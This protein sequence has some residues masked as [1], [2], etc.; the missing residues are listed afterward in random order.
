MNPPDTTPTPGVAPP[1]LQLVG[2]TKRYPAVVANSGVSLTVQPGEVHAVL[3]EN[4]AGKSTL[5]KIIYGTVKPDEGAVHFDGK[6]VSIRNPQEA[7]QLG[8]AMVF[9]HFSLFDTLTVAENVWLGLDKGMPLADVTR[10]ITEV[11][12]EYGMDID[13]LRPV[14]TLSVGEMQRVEIIRALLTNPRLLILDEPTSVLTPQAVEKLFVV[15]KKLA[16]EGCSILYISHKLHEIRELCSACTV[17]RGGVV[18]GV[19]NPQNESNASLS[20]LMIGSEPPALQRQAPKTGDVVLKVQGLSLGKTDQFGVD[21]IDIG[22][23]VRA[24]EVVGIAGVSGN[25]QKELLYALSG[26]DT[27]AAPAMVQVL[28]QDAG[29][30]GPRQRRALGLH[31]V[32]E[33]RLGRGAVPT[34]GLAHN[35][36]LT[37]SDAV[38]SGGWLRMGQ[39]QA[40]AADIIRRFGVKAGGP[41]AAAKSLSGGNL[42]KFIVGREI[43]AKPRLLIVSQPTWGVDVGAAAQI[44]GAMLA[45]RDAGCAVLV[46]SEELDE[47]F[48]ISDRLHVVAKGRLSP[49]V[50]RADASVQKI[51][52]WMSGLWHAEVQ[53]HL[54]RSERQ[55]GAGGQA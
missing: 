42:Q 53:Q 13:P 7:R 37:R 4:G 29:R 3:G 8:I 39:L 5:M 20:R 31:F 23:Q 34:M 41:N 27:R 19:C 51:G 10:R 12:S 11:G 15:L 43:D 55:A 36:L 48:E 18:T 9:Q 32:P 52:E 26:E 14:H 1:R 54:A 16:S 28:G 25:G 50:D 17:L 33:E 6:P 46:L 40:H 49:S 30:M 45:L 47:L 2:I 22:L 44:R 21:L 38:G 24:G 35:L